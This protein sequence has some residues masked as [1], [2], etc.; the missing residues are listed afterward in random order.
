MLDTETRAGNPEMMMGYMYS[1]PMG[2]S[3]DDSDKNDNSTESLT[4]LENRSPASS[5]GKND[6]KLS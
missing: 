1:Q 4:Q 3:S 2:T 5:P 6:N